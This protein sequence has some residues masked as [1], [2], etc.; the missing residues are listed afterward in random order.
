[1]WI[2]NCT[3]DKKYEK[4]GINYLY[5]NKWKY[6]SFIDY[7]YIYYDITDYIIKVK[8]FKINKSGGFVK[9]KNIN[10]KIKFIDSLLKNEDI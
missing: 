5:V 6:M 2:I 4:D 1:M 9:I 7:T 3:N 8:P 10:D